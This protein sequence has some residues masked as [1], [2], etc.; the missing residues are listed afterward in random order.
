VEPAVGIIAGSLVTIR[1]LFRFIFPSASRGNGYSPMDIPEL[2]T[3]QTTA[4]DGGQETPPTGKLEAFY[5]SSF[6]STPPA[7]PQSYSKDGDLEAGRRPSDAATLVESPDKA[8]GK[9]NKEFQFPAAP[10]VFAPNV[11]I[12]DPEPEAQALPLPPPAKISEPARPKSSKKKQPPKETFLFDQ[13][14]DEPERDE[15]LLTSIWNPPNWE[16]R[17]ESPHRVAKPLLPTPSATISSVPENDEAS[18]PLPTA[19]LPL[20]SRFQSMRVNRQNWELRDWDSRAEPI[21]PRQSWLEPEA[22]DAPMAKVRKPKESM[23]KR[24]LS[25][26]AKQNIFPSRGKS[27]IEPGLP[28]DMFF[29]D[30][31]DDDFSDTASSVSRQ[32]SRRTNLSG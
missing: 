14:V 2:A 20:T 28:L 26:K 22:A 5:D 4:I 9:L 16:P 18:P 6:G 10:P 13:T 30:G 32:Q 7:T 29:G 31:A 19:P 25:T 8:R 23:L 24:H 12:R 21:A 27:V 15:P 1:P 3:I 11:L 17:A